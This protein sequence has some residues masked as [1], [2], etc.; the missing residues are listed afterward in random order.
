MDF[1]RKE[2]SSWRPVFL[3]LDMLFKENFIEKIFAQNNN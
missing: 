3:K 1:S 2:I